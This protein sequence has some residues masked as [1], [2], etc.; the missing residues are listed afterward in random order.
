ML[1]YK[2][3]AIDTLTNTELAVLGLLAERPKHGY[4]IEQDIV[5]RGMREWTEIGFSSIY[6]ILNK[7]EAAGWLSSGSEGAQSAGAEAAIDAGMF[8]AGA[9]TSVLALTDHRAGVG[10]RPRSSQHSGPARKVYC[11]TSTGWAGYRAAVRERLAHPRP[12]TGDFDLAL[13]NLP[14]LPPAD[15]RAALETY[16]TH[17]QERM[18]RVR[19]KWAADRAVIAKA[20]IPF[21]SHV[22]ALFDHS[23]VSLEAELNWITSYLS[24]NPSKALLPD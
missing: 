6:Y 3:A 10:V 11:L 13:A 24:A 20:G 16:Y 18:E 7:L 8:A 12:H 23:L 1:E 5:E 4:Q 15:A 17:L 19:A 14:A 22:D 2:E 21:P 9:D